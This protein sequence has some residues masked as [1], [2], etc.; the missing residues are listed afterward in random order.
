MSE[1]IIQELHD[2]ME[3]EYKIIQSSKKRQ[4]T[5]HAGNL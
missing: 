1:N 5:L 2:E 4:M 3:A